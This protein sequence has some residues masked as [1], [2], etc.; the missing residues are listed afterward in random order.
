MNDHG[1]ALGDECAGGLTFENP[2]ELR[3]IESF[4]VPFESSRGGR[5]DLPENV[6]DA[7]FERPTVSPVGIAPLVFGDELF[8]AAFR[9]RRG[10][11]RCVRVQPAPD[12]IPSPLVLGDARRLIGPD[13]ML[14]RQADVVLAVHQ[15]GKTSHRPLRDDLGNEDYASAVLA[16]G[17]ASHVKAQVYLF[18]FRVKGY[19]EAAKEPGVAKLE[20]HQAE[21]GLSTERIELRSSRDILLQ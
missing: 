4:D 7:I 18:K 14:H 17:F 9:Y 11:G 16:A 6:L 8:E 19:G 2:S 21:V 12:A 5:L 13:A 10:R 15:A 1:R 3:P 20:T